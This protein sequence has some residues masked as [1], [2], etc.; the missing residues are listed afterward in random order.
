MGSLRGKVF[1]GLVTYFAGFATAIYALAPADPKGRT[2]GKW[3]QSDKAAHARQVSHEAAAVADVQLRRFL[4]FAEGK[5]V[6][7]GRWIKAELAKADK[8]TE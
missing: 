5:A 3:R 6:E 8:G 7:A 1:A 4:S 2:T